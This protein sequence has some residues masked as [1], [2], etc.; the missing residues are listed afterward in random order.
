[1]KE[2]IYEDKN[3]SRWKDR[4]LRNTTGDREGCRGCD[5]NNKDIKLLDK[6]LEMSLQKEGIKP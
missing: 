2:I 6:K 3:E 1:M 5:V 4:T